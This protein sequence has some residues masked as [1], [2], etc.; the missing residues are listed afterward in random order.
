M[1]TRR[2]IGYLTSEYPRASD[3]FIR[4]EVETLRRKGFDVHTFAVRRPPPEQIVDADLRAA[5]EQTCYLFDGGKR[6]WIGAMVWAL[7]TRPARLFDAT[8]LMW[9]TSPPGLRARVRAV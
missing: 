9:R 6:H 5:N 7:A 4:V 3:S 1:S 2:I 8:L